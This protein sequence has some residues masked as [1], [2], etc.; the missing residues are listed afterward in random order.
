MYPNI[1]AEV[2]TDVVGHAYEHEWGDRSKINVALNEWGE[3]SEKKMKFSSLMT[4]VQRRGWDLEEDGRSGSYY[5]I[6]DESRQ[7]MCNDCEC[8]AMYDSES[9]EFYCPQCES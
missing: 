6:I 9:K 5:K 1:K 4:M 8:R 2:T 3:Q 7:W